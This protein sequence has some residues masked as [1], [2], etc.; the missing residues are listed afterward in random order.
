MWE[1]FKCFNVNLRL[2][3]TT[4]VQVL[5]VLLKYSSLTF[6]FVS[7]QRFKFRTFSNDFLWNNFRPDKYFLTYASNSISMLCT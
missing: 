4:Y 3:K 1:R 5:G 2:L 7:Q 6:L